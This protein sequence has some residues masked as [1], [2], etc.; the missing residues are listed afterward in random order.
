MK[1]GID[2]DEVLQPFKLPFLHFNNKVFEENL[3][4]EDIEKGNHVH[5]LLGCSL[6]EANYRCN[7]FHESEDA[8][9]LMPIAGSI[10]GISKLGEKH[11]LVAITSRSN[12]VKESTLAWLRKHF[13]NALDE[14]YFSSEFYSNGNKSKAQICK[15][16]GV[17]IMVDDNLDFALD[18][19]E[20]NI[21]VILFDLEGKYWWNSTDKEY[22]KLHRVKSWGE[23][24]EKI[25][26]LS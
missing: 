10:E 6:E 24:I 8:D 23:V 4:P 14:I 19:I 26:E 22:D 25:E 12:T 13:G 7:Q 5:D 11:K 2:I 3:N 17:E 9:N 18:C 15:E 21:P 20:E 16:I 1:I